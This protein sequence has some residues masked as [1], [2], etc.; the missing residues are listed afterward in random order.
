MCTNFCRRTQ[1]IHDESRNVFFCLCVSQLTPADTVVFTVQ[2]TDADNDKIIYSIDQTSVSFTLL[3]C[4]GFLHKKTLSHTLPASLLMCLC[5]CV[6]ALQ[7]DAEYFRFD[8]P[9]SGEVV[10]SKPLDYETKTLLT[11]TIHASVSYVHFI[12]DR[13][14]AWFI[15]N[16]YT[17]SSN[18]S[19]IKL[20]FDCS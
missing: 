4:S 14:R 2:A 16:I 9:N 18:P 7:P 20:Q 11:V 5:V 8:L 15:V 10:L 3:V 13:F 17:H 1:N 6:C 19:K 12:F